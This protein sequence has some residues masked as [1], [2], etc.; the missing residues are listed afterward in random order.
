M[1]YCEIKAFG[2]GKVVVVVTN[3]APNMTLVWILLAAKFP[4]ILFEG[5][6]AHMLNLASK[7]IAE[8]RKIKDAFGCSDSVTF[9]RYVL[10]FRK[11]TH[12]LVLAKLRWIKKKLQPFCSRL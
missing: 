2:K 4:W 9:L 11:K 1:R 7:D 10:L 12:R 5:C 6:K 3:H 8:K